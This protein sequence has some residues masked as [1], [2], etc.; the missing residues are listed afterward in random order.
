MSQSNED[1]LNK[2]R[3]RTGKDTAGMSVVCDKL[4]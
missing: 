3:T 1:T 2:R 4:N